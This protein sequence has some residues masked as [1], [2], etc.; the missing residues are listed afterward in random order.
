MVGYIYITTNKVNGKK[1]IGQRRWSKIETIEGDVY[2]G[3]GLVLK[4]AIKKYGTDSFEKIIICLC[5]TTDDLNTKEKDIISL[6]NAVESDEFY[7]IHVGGSGGNTRAGYSEEQMEEFKTKM[8]TARVGYTHSKETIAKI[9]DLALSRDSH[10][11]QEKYRKMFSEMFMGENNPMY[12]KRLSDEQIDKLRRS[13]NGKFDYNKGKKMSEE[14]KQKISV[15]SKKMWD[16]AENRE[17]WIQSRIGA[18]RSDSAKKNLSDGA[19]KRY[20]SF[21]IDDE[22][23]IYR[24]N[25]NMVIEDVFHG[26]AEYFDK[27]RVNTVRNLRYAIK[28]NT[29][30]RGSYWKIEFSGQSTIENKPQEKNL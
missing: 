29:V 6:Y 8:K 19:Y 17:K 16:N 4:Q 25:K 7:N 12:G 14:Q 10:M 22:C 3:S 5:D 26:V 24:Y 30:F 23:I 27:Y 11:K 1:Y 15:A 28:D 2:L 18:K 20:D 21:P 13:H 9:R